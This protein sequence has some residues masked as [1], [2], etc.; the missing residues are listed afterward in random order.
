MKIIL[1]SSSPRRV[2]LLQNIFPAFNCFPPEV[3]EVQN[4]S[5]PVETL[6]I[7]N[8]HLKLNDVWQKL[9]FKEMLVIAADTIV[10]TRKGKILGKPRGYEEAFSFL[11][12]LSGDFHYVITGISFATQTLKQCT[13]KSFAE[14]ST[15]YFSKLSSSQI[16]QYLQQFNPLDK[17]GAYGIQELPPKWIEKVEGSISNVIG[18]PLETLHREL[19]VQRDALNVPLNLL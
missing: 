18:L 15:V 12:L 19:L 6:V 14:N 8:A 2:E 11:K 4:E 5:I 1:A 10:L 13:R 7:N 3:K 17:A 9:S 16:D